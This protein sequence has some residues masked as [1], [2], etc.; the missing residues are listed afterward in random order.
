MLNQSALAKLP[1]VPVQR[2]IGHA[3][4]MAKRSRILR[5]GTKRTN[6][7]YAAGVRKRGQCLPYRFESLLPRQSGPYG[8]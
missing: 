2:G 3:A 5:T 7:G 6:D 4:L 1:K 8:V